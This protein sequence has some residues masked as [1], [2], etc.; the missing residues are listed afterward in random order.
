MPRVCGCWTGDESKFETETRRSHL[1]RSLKSTASPTQALHRF[2]EQTE[3][4]TDILLERNAHAITPRRLITHVSVALPIASALLAFSFSP[5]AQSDS[6]APKTIPESDGTAKESHAIPITSMHVGVNAD[7]RKLRLSGCS[8][9]VM[10]ATVAADQ[11]PEPSRS[12]AQT[13]TVDLSQDSNRNTAAAAMTPSASATATITLRIRIRPQ[14]P[15]R[16]STP[17]SQRAAIVS[18]ASTR[19]QGSPGS[20]EEA[21]KLAAKAAERKAKVLCRCTQPPDR[22]ASSTPAR[23]PLKALFQSKYVRS[24]CGI[25]DGNP[26]PENGPSKPGR[27]KSTPP[28]TFRFA[29]VRN[30]LLV[31][32]SYEHETNNRKTAAELHNARWSCVTIPGQKRITFARYVSMLLTIST[33]HRPATD[34]GFCFTSIPARAILLI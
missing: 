18:M 29:A 9:L 27:S 2:K 3:R 22:P 19:N 7:A 26:Q 5:P 11:C 16:S 1:I 6:S 32:Q 30:S 14:S 21:I 31:P 24:K 23:E 33:T 15:P 17:R 10:D 12:A 4:G 13:G 25:Y 34:L 8:E 20:R 28:P